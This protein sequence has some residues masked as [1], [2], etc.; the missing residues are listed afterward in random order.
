MK[1]QVSNVWVIVYTGVDCSYSRL[2]LNAYV[3]SLGG[4][5]GF[6]TGICG[7]AE[8][9]G[10]SQLPHKAVEAEGKDG[11]YHRCLG[12]EDVRVRFIDIEATVNPDTA[13][14]N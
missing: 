14:M 10:L 3:H 9:F 2:W 12:E 5:G 13:E 1:I 8:L 11:D 4:L 6:C 7:Q